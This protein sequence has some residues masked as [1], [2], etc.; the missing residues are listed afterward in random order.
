MTYRRLNTCTSLN[1]QDPAAT[2]V[3]LQPVSIYL[4]QAFAVDS[5]S[6]LAEKIL[7]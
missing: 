5:L 7:L 3:P 2:K 4:M 1:A 6:I